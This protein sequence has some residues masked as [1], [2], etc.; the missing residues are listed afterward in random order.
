[1]VQRMGRSQGSVN[2]PR[3][4]A[5]SRTKTGGTSESLNRIGRI[6]PCEHHLT[7]ETTCQGGATSIASKL[8]SDHGAIVVEDAAHCLRL[9]ELVDD[10]DHPA[11][12]LRRSDCRIINPEFVPK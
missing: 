7:S 2:Q 4:Q 9:I 6:L 1:M 3:T 10:R 12:A 11:N 8:P 5:P